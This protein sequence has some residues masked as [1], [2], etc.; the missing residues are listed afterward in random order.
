[1]SDTIDLIAQPADGPPDPPS[2]PE[3]ALTLEVQPQRHSVDARGVFRV[4]VEHASADLT[5]FVDSPDAAQVFGRLLELHSARLLC[6][7][8]PEMVEERLEFVV[9]FAAADAVAAS[10]GSDAAG[11]WH[12]DLRQAAERAPVFSGRPSAQH[13]DHVAWVL[14]QALPAALG[15]LAGGDAPLVLD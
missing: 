15:A 11:A 5:P 3:S 9:S 12:R 8:S 1:M 6:W 10:A 4:L 7:A 13:G 14:Q 2:I